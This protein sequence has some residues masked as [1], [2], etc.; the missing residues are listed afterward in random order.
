MIRTPPQ[1]VGWFLAAAMT[2]V[3]PR[4]SAQERVAV[5]G[6]SGPEAPAARAAVIR[7]V[8]QEYDVVDL[9]EWMRAVVE[10]N[11]RGSSPRNLQRVAESLGVRAIVTGGVRRVRRQFRVNVVVRDGAT[12]EVI[13]RGGR[14]MRSASRASATGSALGH[15]VLVIIGTARGASSRGDHGPPE[16]EHEAEYPERR[17]REPDIEDAEPDSDDIERARPPD[18]DG[19][20]ENDEGERPQADDV[21]EAPRRGARREWEQDGDREHEERDDRDRDGGN[22]RTTPHGWLDLSIEIN[23]ASR[24]FTVPID[25]ETDT[26]GRDAARSESNIYPEIGTRLV[27]YFGGLFTD[28]WPANIGVEGSFHHHLFLRIMNRERD[29]EVISEE[30]SLT[31]GLNYRI[32]V[33]NSER[34]V[35]LWPRFGY[36][37]FFFFLG[38]VGNDIVPPFVY[39]HLYIG[40]NVY[41]PIA[42][43]HVGIDLGASYLAVLRI[44]DHATDAYNAEGQF[45]TTHGFQILAGLSGEI[46]AGLRWRLAFELQGFYSTH[47]G[48]GSGWGYEPTTNIS[49]A[50][51]RG[52][53]TLGSAKDIFFRLMPQ[54]SYRFGWRP[55]EERRGDSRENARRRESRDASDRDGG[56]YDDSHDSSD[57]EEEGDWDEEDW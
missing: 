51:G 2:L 42:T 15:R 34:G 9:P 39:D 13:G 28:T 32:V 18:D 46:A 52:I 40:L 53:Q 27:F 17:D 14:A 12:G 36:G 10:L 54:L 45:P 44:G 1:L 19:R 7:A 22:Q 49:T 29:Q 56:W 16:A 11:A 24:S 30:Y 43:R 47:R 55:D 33:G 3:S 38:D 57:G 31:V 50:S 25:P 6:F 5:L 21:E 8:R 41:V 4:I 26:V 20:Y 23:G 48:T 35:T 37:R